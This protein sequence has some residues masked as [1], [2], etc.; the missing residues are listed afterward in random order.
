MIAVEVKGMDPKHAWEIIG[1]YR[2]ANEDMLAIESLA[3][4]NLTTRNLTKRSFIG[5]DMHLTQTEWKGNAEKGSGF[6]TIANKLVWD[7]D[8]TQLVSGLTR[9]DALMDI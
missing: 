6:Q 7:N 9:G 1:I 3:A 2:A 5:S 4:H 8:Y